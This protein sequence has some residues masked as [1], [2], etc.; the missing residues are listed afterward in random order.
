MRPGQNKRMRGRNRR[1]PNPLTRSFESNGPDVK[2]RGTAQH[3]AE[4]YTQ[5]AR[6]AHLSGDP[7][8][9]ESYLQHAEH[10]YRIIA[11]AFQSQQAAQNGTA[12]ER[13]DDD[14]DDFD[15]A[16]DRF[17]FRSPQTVHSQQ[18]GGQPF[19]GDRQPSEFSENGEPRAEG[20][21]QPS[22]EMREHQ[23][24]GERPF[25]NRPQGNRNFRDDRRNGRDR[26]DRGD[27]NFRN[28]E[29]P[30][31]GGQDRNAEGRSQEP[32]SQEGRV[33]EPR[34]PRSQEGRSHEPRE[35][36]SHE[37]RERPSFQPRPPRAERSEIV[38]EVDEQPG[39]PSFLTA[40]V[41]P[42][43]IDTSADDA[44]IMAEGDAS[45]GPFRARRRRRPRAAGEAAVETSGGDEG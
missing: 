19:I 32:R 11:A 8:A 4:K 14:D 3:I 12:D 27:R 43:Q 9:A 30:E 18:Q 7:V 26:N 5:L 45:G 25:E 36:R 35:P 16:S 10:Y 23:P 6:D 38:A 1:G 34:E 13:D 41:R 20:D 33:Y 40:P 15:P 31:F 17:T 24:R 22:S 44:G 29:R 28:R 42:I 21:E 39:L 2:V 37:G